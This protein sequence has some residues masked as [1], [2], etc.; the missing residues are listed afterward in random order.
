MLEEMKHVDL[1]ESSPCGESST[2]PDPERTA[3]NV[4]I[5]E[6]EKLERQLDEDK[7]GLLLN[8]AEITELRISVLQNILKLKE[9]RD[10][11]PKPKTNLRKQKSCILFVHRENRPKKK[12]RFELLPPARPSW[13][14][15]R[16]TVPSA[17]F[18]I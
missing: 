13:S 2:A 17:A 8:Q 18:S 4:S 9:C 11:M 5:E 16:F 12:V 6:Y 10:D 14:T 3:Y 7:V 1:V 15:G